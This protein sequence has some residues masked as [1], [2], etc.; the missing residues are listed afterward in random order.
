MSVSKIGEQEVTNQAR[1]H[2]T[3]SQCHRLESYSS[4]HGHSLARNL[5]SGVVTTAEFDHNGNMNIKQQL[6]LIIT[7]FLS[8]HSAVHDIGVE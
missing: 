3:K 2:A 1:S 5:P 8:Q 7:I 6:H 4:T